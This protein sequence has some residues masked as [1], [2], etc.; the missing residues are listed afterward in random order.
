MPKQKNS[1][2]EYRNYYLPVDFPVLILSGEHWKISDIPSSRL[3]FHN[4]L[5]IGLCHSCSGTMKF[6]SEPMTF[7]AGDVTCIPRNIPHTTYSDKGTE[8][9]WSYIMFDPAELFRALLP[10]SESGPDLSL[11]SYRNYRHILPRAEYPHI[12]YLTQSIIDEMENTRPNYQ[13]CVKGL[14]LALSIELNRIQEQANAPESTCGRPTSSSGPDAVH[15]IPENALVISPALDYIEDHYSSQFPIEVLADLC[16]MSLTHFRRVFHSIMQT[17]PL[18]YLNSTRIMKACNLL[19]STEE[20]IL[21]ISEMAGFA[22]VSNFNRHFHAVIHMT[23]RE[24][25]NQMLFARQKEG[26]DIR[27][28]ILEFSGWMEPESDPL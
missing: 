23:P 16:H 20:S 5:E 28:T 18:D 25:R 1:V 17:N 8:S 2:M 13:S 21:S 4:C 9:R 27:H 15:S 14:L 12:H 3:H 26:T 22:S 24:Y 19:R 11:F 6:Y 7:K 10:A